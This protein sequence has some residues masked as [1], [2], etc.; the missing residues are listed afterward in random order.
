MKKIEN[1]WGNLFCSVITGWLTVYIILGHPMSSDTLSTTVSQNFLLTMGLLIIGALVSGILG[2]KNRR[3]Q[4]LLLIV[5]IFIAAVLSL[6]KQQDGFTALGYAAI[7]GIALY[8]FREDILSVLNRISISDRL[9]K[10]VYLL[11]GLLLFLMLALTG[12]FHYLSYASEGH[13]LGIFTQM[14]E[15]MLTTGRQLTTLE[16]DRLM[17]HFAVHNSPIYY[18]LLPIFFFFRSAL[19]LQICQAILVSISLYPFYL[20][21][22]H[23][24]LSGKVCLLL[25]CMY[26][27]YPALVGGCLNDFHENCFLPV[28]LLSLIYALEKD[29]KWS[30]V[31][32][33]G[34]SLMVK[35]DV[36][37]QLMV[38]ALFFI[39]SGKN[40]KKGFIMMG[41]SGLYLVFSLWLLSLG[42]EGGVL[43]YMD[44]MYLTENGGIL[45]VVKTIVMNPGYTLRQCFLSPEKLQYIGWMI[46]PIGAALFVRQQYSRYILVLYMIFMNLVPAYGALNNINRQYHFPIIIFLFYII[47][48]NVAEWESDR[49]CNILPALAGMTL[50]L[51]TVS[52][53]QS[54]LC[55]GIEALQNRQTTKKLEEAVAMVPTE[56]SVSAS[57]LIVTHLTDHKKLYGLWNEE[58]TEYIIVDYRPKAETEYDVVQEWIDAGEYEEL[59]YEPDVVKVYKRQ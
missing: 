57:S 14:Y 8:L 35:E 42:S 47:M 59:W 25:G 13:D 50:F 11:L 52:V 32:F 1:I 36:S 20:L 38:L 51:F 19:T 22:R 44:N 43:N 9:L 53:F 29:R 21:C 2:Q 5:V 6:F 30:F 46:L 58:N 28:L 15:Y 26:V 12:C 41:V 54:S 39:V 31:I 24:G 49:K 10:R 34:L 56:A 33:M 18:V 48:M 16:R 4:H 3:A 23:F 55:V 40:R 7:L 27:C 17:S 45:E 37:L